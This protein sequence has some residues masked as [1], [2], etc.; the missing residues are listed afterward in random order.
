MWRDDGAGSQIAE[1]LQDCPGLHAIDGG[2]VPENHF[3]KVVQ[4]RPD[5]ILMIDAGD[6]GGEPGELRLLQP[7]EVALSGLSTHA[8]SANMLAQYLNARCGA[9]VGLLAIQPGDVSEGE[10]LSPAVAAA[11]DGLVKE[12]LEGVGA[13]HARDVLR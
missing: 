7:D 10:Q 12:L 9:K 4:T 8:G 6:F 1:A 2:M 5:T 13:G 3:E 11:M